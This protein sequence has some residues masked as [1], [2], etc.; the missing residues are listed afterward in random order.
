[1]AR[2]SA[3]SFNTIDA[4]STPAIVGL[5]LQCSLVAKNTG[6]IGCSPAMLFFAG[7]EDESYFATLEMQISIPAAVL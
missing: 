3:T 6:E 1:M 2:V 4:G 5:A 7:G